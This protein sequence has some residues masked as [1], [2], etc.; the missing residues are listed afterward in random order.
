MKSSKNLNKYA[1][2]RLKLIRTKNGF[3]QLQLAELLGVNRVSI[4]NIE[5][6]IHSLTISHIY[7]VCC[8]F[9]VSPVDLLPKIVPAKL[10]TKVVR[11][12]VTKVINLMKPLK[13]N[14]KFK[15]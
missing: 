12:R 6:G 2:A 9:N 1:G 13:L 3:T 7:L 8:I 11:V 10:K 4:C 14:T 15:A 5:R